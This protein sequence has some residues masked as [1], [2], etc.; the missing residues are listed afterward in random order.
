M[1]DKVIIQDVS[2]G[3]L[4]R[5]KLNSNFQNIKDYIEDKS[6]SRDNEPGCPNQMENELDMNSNR[7]INLADG[8]NPKDGVNLSQLQTL[9]TGEEVSGT[10][11][12]FREIV[13]PVAGQFTIDF[14]TI[15]F[16]PGIN[17]LSIYVDGVHQI[18]GIDYNE[19]DEDSVTFIQPF[20]GNETVIA[21]I[22]ET[23]T[24]NYP[25][26][27]FYQEFE[28]IATAGQSTYP[29]GMADLSDNPAATYVYVNGI[30][31][32]GNYTIVTNG[33][34]TQ[35]VVFD[36]G[37][38]AQIEDGD[39][40]ALR[41]SSV[42]YTGGG[43]GGGGGINFD[44][45]FNKQGIWWNIVNGEWEATPFTLGRH[46]LAAYQAGPVPSSQ[47][48]FKYTSVDKYMLPEN[49]AGSEAE[50]TVAPSADTTFDIRKNAVSIGS[51]VILNGATEGTFTFA[52]EVS[53]VAGDS[54]EVVSPSTTNGMT[55]LSLSLKGFKE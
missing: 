11:A 16:V 25:A 27:N 23:T 49:L 39:V 41:T 8:I 53:F 28:I 36:A 38:A 19:V 35:D 12:R 13:Y 44:G 22:N 31:Q 5:S 14:T 30:I 10:V 42:Y 55:E 40:V 21:Y 20:V 54:L 50:C 47:T 34:A 33:S 24:T 43:A 26:E 3:H 18:N 32:T 29:T 37:T 52:S 4:S 7:I 1:A 17:N 9:I 6:L 46:T 2:S 51:F 15:N 48:W 45:D